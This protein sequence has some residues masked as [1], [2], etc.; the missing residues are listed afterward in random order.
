MGKIGV[1]KKKESSGKP[2]LS[3]AFYGFVLAGPTGLDALKSA[4]PAARD[5][6]K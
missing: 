6:F 4:A 3:F 2:E 5:L 1:S